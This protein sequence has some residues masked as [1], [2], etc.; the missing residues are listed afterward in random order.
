MKITELVTALKLPPS[1]LIVVHD[2]MDIDIGKCKLKT[3]GSAR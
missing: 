1:R 3:R 2:D